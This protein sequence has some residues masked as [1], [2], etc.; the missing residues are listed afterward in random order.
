MG[1]T[2]R[3]R[4][5]VRRPDNAAG[6]GTWRSLPDGGGLFASNPIPDSFAVVDTNG[7]KDVRVQQEN[8]EFGRTDA[9][10]QLLVPDLQSFDLNHLSID[11]TDIPPDAT[12]GY[13]QREV[14][15]QDR[16]GVVVRF[17]IKTSRAALL[18]LTDEAGQRIPLGSV[19]TLKSTGA[20]MPVGYEGKVYLVDLEPR[21]EVTVE[22][23]NGQRCGV[24]FD[25]R[26]KP[27]DIPVIGPIRCREKAH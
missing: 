1:S 20:A 16:S 12:V 2:F 18:Q 9:S 6:R 7:F 3:R 19:A 10:G 15:P 13:T 22:R 24:T 11:P 25:Y 21:N 26:P 14:R 27:G 5:P 4:R 17:P 8:R 23:R